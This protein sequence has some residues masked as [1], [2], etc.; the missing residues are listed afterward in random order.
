MT[1]DGTQFFPAGD[2]VKQL[3]PGYYAIK[4]SMSGMYFEQLPTKAEKL[5]IFPD[6][7]TQA[8][9]EE[10]E[11]FWLL[12]D[13]FREDSIPY[14]RG[15]IMYGPPGSGKTCTLRLVVENLTNKHNGMVIDFPGPRMFIEGYKVIRQIHPRM[16]LVIM[17]ED[18]D[19]ILMRSSESEVLN[20]LDGM[21]DV[22]KTIFL[23]TTNY[24]EKLG[25]RIMNRPSRFDKKIFID[26]PSME[27]R[28]MFIR[29]K[30]IKEDEKTIKRWTEDT[31]GFSIAHIKELYVANRILGED[32]RQALEILK[33]M[34]TS[35]HSSSFDDYEVSYDEP[36]MAISC[37]WSRFGTGKVFKEAMKR[38][39]N[40]I[41]EIAD[42]LGE[43]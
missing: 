26:M 29:S 3:P 34:K 38:K 19:A 6:S 43:I 23:A 41:C 27:A 4:E 33:K 18:L 14:K 40:P 7:G 36:K 17:M 30:L 15:I 35:P 12:E 20:L 24:P 42:N 5:M 39:S 9:V 28:E 37:D 25:S 2:V 32:Y 10:I 31:D 13:R 16:P 8:V 21:H 22:D 1:S 11:K